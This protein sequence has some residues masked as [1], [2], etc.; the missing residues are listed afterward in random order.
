[1]IDFVLSEEHMTLLA[2][3]NQLVFDKSSQVFK[4]H[5]LTTEE[6]RQSCEDIKVY[7]ICMHVYMTIRPLV[8]ATVSK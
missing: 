6:I 3:V 1:M 2:S 5:P 4:R 7:I 8:N